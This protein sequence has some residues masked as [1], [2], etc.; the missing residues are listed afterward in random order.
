MPPWP[1]FFLASVVAVMLILK[2]IVPDTWTI[3]R[4]TAQCDALPAFA[5]A[6]PKR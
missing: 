5:R 2:I 6:Q 3:D 1:I 4:I